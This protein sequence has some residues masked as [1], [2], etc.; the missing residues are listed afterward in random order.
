MDPVCLALLRRGGKSPFPKPAEG[1][2]GVF[3]QLDPGEG[4]EDWDRKG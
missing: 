1:G 3:W 4:K 2:F